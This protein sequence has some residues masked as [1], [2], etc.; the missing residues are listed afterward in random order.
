VAALNQHL[1]RSGMI[2]SNGYGPLKGKNFRIAH[3]GDTQMEDLEALFTAMDEF[4]NES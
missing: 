1:R 4:L 2:I 3:M